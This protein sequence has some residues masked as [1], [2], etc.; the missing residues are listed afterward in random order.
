[1]LPFVFFAANAAI[2]AKSAVSFTDKVCNHFT[3]KQEETNAVIWHI[4]V[5]GKNVDIS[6][7][8]EYDAFTNLFEACRR[9]F[10]TC[11]EDITKNKEGKYLMLWS[12]LRWA[13]EGDDMRV[14]CNTILNKSEEIK[15]MLNKAIDQITHQDKVYAMMVADI[16]KAQEAVPRKTY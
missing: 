3:D 14:L 5:L 8:W 1:M 6:K 15:S 11:V 2:A 9:P 7:D 16:I 4:D 10:E 13:C 12:L